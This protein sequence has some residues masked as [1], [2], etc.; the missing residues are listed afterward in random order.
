[1]IYTCLQAG[2]KDGV[3]LSSAWRYLLELSSGIRK[4]EAMHTKSN[5]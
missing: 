5:T 3:I 2:L 1:M 4:F